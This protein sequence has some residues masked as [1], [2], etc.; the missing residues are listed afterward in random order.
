MIFPLLAPAL[1]VVLNGAIVH[2]YNPPYL[3]NGRVV[4]PLEPY[5]TAVAGRI[6]YNG[7]SLS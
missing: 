1:V 2:S 3:H 7:S 5:V 6:G 4:A